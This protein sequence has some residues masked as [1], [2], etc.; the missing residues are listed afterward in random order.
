METITIVGA[1]IA[2]LT[3]AITCAEAGAPV[4]LYDAHEHAGGRARTLD[5]PYRANLGP[6]VFYGDGELWRWLQDKE[7]LPPNEGIPL[8]GLRLR[9]DGVLHRTPP[10]ALIPA[11]LRLRGRRAPADES[12]RAWAAQHTDERTAGQLSAAAG[13]YSFY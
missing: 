2:G 9:W 1:G 4:V 11:M 5:G 12:F 8:A 10:L 6:H 13:V 7:L 3:A